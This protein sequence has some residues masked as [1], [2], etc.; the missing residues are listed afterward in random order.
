MEEK[1]ILSLINEAKDITKHAYAPYSQY[2]VGCA[3]LLADGTTIKGVNIEN[4]SYS[5]T[6][7]AERSA[8]AQVIT[9]GLGGEIRALA[10]VTKSSPPGFP[11]G[12]CR[13]FLAEFIKDDTPIIAANFSLTY[14]VTTISELL[15][16]A[17]NRHS[18]I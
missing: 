10:I 5:V 17:F 1:I 18:L 13:Q 7:C 9:Q 16:S 15:P 11:C 2:L 12:T 8:M 14:Q 4:A 6:L 3:I